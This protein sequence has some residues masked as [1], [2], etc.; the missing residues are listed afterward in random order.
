MKHKALSEIQF[1]EFTH[2]A[3]TNPGALRR[4]RLERFADLLES[5][6]GPMRLFSQIEAVPDRKLRPLRR[7]SSPFSVA[8]VDPVF[9][10]EGLAGDTIGEGRAFFFLS[11]SETHELVC[12]CHYFGP[13][14]GRTVAERAR[15]MAAH[16][17]LASRFSMFMVRI[18]ARGSTA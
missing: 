2:V 1:T 6:A 9:H 17:S 12:D 4:R 16:P 15:S 10:A 11:S 5:H 7:D 3:P 13:V 8:F 14:T 18:A